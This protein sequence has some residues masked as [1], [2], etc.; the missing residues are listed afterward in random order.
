MFRKKLQNFLF[1]KYL[2]SICPS[3]LG[4]NILKAPAVLALKNKSV[5]CPYSDLVNRRT[6]VFSAVRMY[7]SAV[8][9]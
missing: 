4:R 2:D 1:D 5:W 7:S 6:E 3:P 9:A 8:K